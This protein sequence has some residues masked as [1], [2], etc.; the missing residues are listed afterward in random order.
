MSVTSYII[1]FL[2]SIFIV[3]GIAVKTNIEVHNKEELSMLTCGWPLEFVKNNQ[4]W[5]DPPFPHKIG[6]ISGEL[7]DPKI[8]WQI[9]LV[10]VLMFYFAFVMIGEAYLLTR[11][12][13]VK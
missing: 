1:L 3:F 11:K 13:K 10:N 4:D 2:L 9:F 8:D 5:R 6:C 12:T 7:Q